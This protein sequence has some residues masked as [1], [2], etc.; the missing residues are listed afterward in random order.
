MDGAIISLTNEG[1]ILNHNDVSPMTLRL[2]CCFILFG[3][4]SRL[5]SIFNSSIISD[6]LYS[7]SR[8]SIDG[9]ILIKKFLIVLLSK[10]DRIL[11]GTLMTIG[12]FLR[13]V[14]A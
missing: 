9:A 2:I 12:Y 5:N 1:I 4:S 10:K 3:V 8:A 11:T 14:L 7:P 6:N 13:D